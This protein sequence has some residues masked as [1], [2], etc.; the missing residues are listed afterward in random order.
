M[1]N[2]R[3]YLLAGFLLISIGVAFA[4]DQERS[5]LNDYQKAQYF[6]NPNQSKIYEAFIDPNWVGIDDIFWYEKKGINIKEYLLVNLDLKE[7]RPLFDRDRL[8]HELSEF[9]NDT[10]DANNLPLQ[11]L[12]YDHFKKKIKFNFKNKLLIFDIKNN[13]LD[14]L[15]KQ[16]VPLYSECLSPD[17]KIIAFVKNYNLFIKELASDNEI[18]ITFDGEKHFSYAT[19]TE[20]NLSYVTNIRRKRPVSPVLEWSPDSKKILTYQLDERR[21]SS[22]HLL[23]MID[24]DESLRPILY[25]YKYPVPGDSIIPLAYPIVID[26][27]KKTLTKLDIPPMNATYVGPIHSEYKRIWWSKSGKT[28]EALW[29]DRCL[30]EIQY[31]LIDPTNGSSDVLISES[32]SSLVSSNVDIFVKPNVRYF[33][34]GEFIWFSE[35]SGFGHIYL[36]GKDKQLKNAIT[37]GEYV[38]RDIVWVDEKNRQVYFTATGKE[39]NVDPYFFHFYKVDFKGDN[40]KLL[41]PENSDQRIKLSAN[42]K[43]FI[44]NNA[45]NGFPTSIVRDINGRFIMDL[46]SSDF[47]AWTSKGWQLPERVKML[48]DD[49]VTEIY[50]F[51]FK[52]SNFNE[53]ALFPI[54]D[55]VYPGPQTNNVWYIGYDGPEI[56]YLR[57]QFA[58]AE[59]GF[60]VIDM[61]GRGTPFRSKKFL[62]H[63]YND[64]GF[65]GGLI[66]HVSGIKQLSRQL[67]Y[68]DSSRVGVFGH[69]GGGYASTRAILE[70]PDFYDVA[71]SSAGNHDSRGYLSIW[72]DYYMCKKDTIAYEDQSNISLV[73]NLKGKLM[74]MTGDLDD[75]V[76]PSMTINL[77]HALIKANKDFDFL[78]IP[79]ANHGNSRNTYFLRKRWDYFYRNLLDKEPPT[80][81]KLSLD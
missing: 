16:F 59:L 62:N 14:S 2:N 79:N 75:N 56:E 65:A 26:I 24:T 30:S 20:S 34:S 6:L 77:V 78:L 13:T 12:E 44:S 74:L 51:I 53:N 25:T 38:V 40:I 69:S 10:V 45:W 42:H 47:S 80:N 32:G 23:Q 17:G 27:E 61:D 5:P 36:Y 11:K 31:F 76:H 60:I 3:K 21:V 4:Q 37:S 67:S 29:Q 9:S 64:L 22:T 57:H 28:I 18:Q 58:T 71:V 49:G 70:F 48:A 43:Y 41:T 52:P 81:F 19:T 7:K 63:S 15:T 50:G 39:E 55:N 1:K 8:A 66:D 68:I 35:R 54:L 33:N 46:E 72:M 73:G